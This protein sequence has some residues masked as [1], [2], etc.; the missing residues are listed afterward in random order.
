MDDIYGIFA[1]FNRLSPKS[2]IFVFI[3]YVVHV[4]VRS[5]CKII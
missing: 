3:V 2:V 4:N 5:R 1:F